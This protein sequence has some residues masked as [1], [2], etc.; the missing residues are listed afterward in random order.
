M[1]FKDYFEIAVSNISNQTIKRSIEN[2]M[3]QLE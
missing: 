2:E 3:V 1:L